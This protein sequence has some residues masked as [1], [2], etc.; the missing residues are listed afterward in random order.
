MSWHF[1]GHMKG[2]SRDGVAML[3]GD[4]TQN[5]ARPAKGPSSV[6]PERGQMLRHVRVPHS[7]CVCGAEMSRHV[8]VS[9]FVRHN[10]TAVSQP[11]NAE[12]D[13]DAAAARRCRLRSIGLQGT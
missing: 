4:N 2:C 5:L 1:F 11:L 13:P 12:E 6:V 8:R 10:A 3:T 7:V 9:H